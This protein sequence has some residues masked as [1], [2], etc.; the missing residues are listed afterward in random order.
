MRRGRE[1]RR[2]VGFRQS[3]R[4]HI[5]PSRRPACLM[6]ER[7]GSLLPRTNFLQAEVGSRL[8]GRSS[9][10]E[11]AK[12]VT[13]CLSLACMRASLPPNAAIGRA[14]ILFPRAQRSCARGVHVPPCQPSHL[15]LMSWIQLGSEASRMSAGRAGI[16]GG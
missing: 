4:I 14:I 10:S 6:L 2:A 8:P 15:R 5:N 13:C 9:V 3:E 7:S 12:Q 1:G 11:R 16:K